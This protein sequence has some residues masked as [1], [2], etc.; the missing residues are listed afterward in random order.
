MLGPALTRTQTL[1]PNPNPNPKPNP[2]PDEAVLAA[3]VS[4]GF[5]VVGCLLV[6]LFFDRITPFFL[7]QP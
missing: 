5:E 4:G 2:H 1:D 3:T 6:Q 7:T